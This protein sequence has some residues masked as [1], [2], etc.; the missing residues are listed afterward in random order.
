M[1]VD[2]CL[3]LVISN[4]SLFSLLSFTLGAIL[5]YLIKSHSTENDN[6]YACSDHEQ[7]A[8]SYKDAR[9]EV[10]LQLATNKIID[11]PHKFFS[12]DIAKDVVTYCREIDDDSEAGS[13][14][15]YDEEKKEHVDDGLDE[16]NT[17]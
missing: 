4:T 1:V 13:E 11:D 15:E 14:E 5:G 8:K 9:K 3:S 10:L 6:E 16:R 7:L 17:Y 2:Q 12:N